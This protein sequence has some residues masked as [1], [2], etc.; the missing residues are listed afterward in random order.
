ME[1]RRST[2]KEDW[3]VGLASDTSLPIGSRLPLQRA[4]MKRFLSIQ[5]KDVHTP[6]KD[7]FKVI[8]SELK[9]IWGKAVI[10]IKSDHNCLKQLLSIHVAWL[11]LKK[12]PLARR[13]TPHSKKLIEQFEKRMNK[14]CDL[15]PSDTS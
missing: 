14:L 12:I 3:L 9:E 10:P 6:V 7:I 1:T 8:L 13:E 15:S 11:S 4:V 5:L 2:N